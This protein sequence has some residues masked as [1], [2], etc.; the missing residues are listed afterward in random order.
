MLQCPHCEYT[1]VYRNNLNLHISRHTGSN[2]L[3]CEH[4]EYTTVCKSQ[5]KVHISRHTGSNM[6]E[7]PHCDYTTVHKGHLKAHMPRHTGVGWLV[8]TVCGY[9]TGDRSNFHRHTRRHDDRNR[10][11]RCHGARKISENLRASESQSQSLDSSKAPCLD[12]PKTQN[13]RLDPLKKQH[14]SL[15]LQS[16]QLKCPHCPFFTKRA[17]YLHRHVREMHGVGYYCCQRCDYN[18]DLLR[19]LTQHERECRKKMKNN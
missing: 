6:L 9:K 4:C 10:A 5:L 17:H 11:K 8:C 7:C 3:K 18:C 15:K 13:R 2:M 19:H 14:D 1:T 16:K 12:S